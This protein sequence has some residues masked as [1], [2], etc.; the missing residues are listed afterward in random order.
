MKYRL[1]I[2]GLKIKK[3]HNKFFLI[4]VVTFC[5]C[6]VFYLIIYISDDTTF[7]VTA[8]TEQIEFRTF[9]SDHIRI[10][11]D[12][13]IINNYDTILD[14]NYIGS[15]EIE[16]SSKV[17][18]ERIANGPLYIMVTGNKHN[19]AGVFYDTLGNFNHDAE[20]FVEFYFA[21][22][23]KGV[24]ENQNIIIPISGEVI[25]GR[26]VFYQTYFSPTSLVK[27]GKVTMI[28]KS[29]FRN[30]YF[31]SGEHEFNIGD[32]FIVEGGKTSKAYGFV[33]I[34]KNS[35]VGGLI[36]SYK[37]VGK[38]GRIITSG[39]REKNAGYFISATIVSRFLYDPVFKAVGW[40]FAIL[41]GMATFVTFFN[42]STVL[43]QTYSK[44]RKKPKKKKK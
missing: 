33:T 34:N 39:P 24:F 5:M 42:E 30:N 28:S 11:L 7:N 27:S 32:Q 19:N 2:E 18:I 43:L 13:V 6:F 10:S 40:A 15:F 22:P 4:T 35:D 20:N 36:A 16:D 3:I 23:T 1:K 17:I 9:E 8:N 12:N 25:L 31:V 38:K 41:F 26:S 29:L 21:N 44:K 37:V 14:N